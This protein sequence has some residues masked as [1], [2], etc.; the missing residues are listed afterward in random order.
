MSEN[1]KGVSLGAGVVDDIKESANQELSEMG[2]MLVGIF[3]KFLKEKIQGIDLEEL[4]SKKNEEELV[5]L[6]SSQLAEKGLV[7]K[8]YSGLP[9]DLLIS[10][11]HQDG[12]LDGLYA[13]YILSMMALVDN[14]APEE[15]IL[16]VRD[17]VSPNLIGH[18]YDDRDEFF[19]R[20]KDQKYNWINVK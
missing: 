19:S 7:P 10:N 16:S 14:D 18:H 5:A 11:M 1:K 9:E 13:G 4:F 3:S 2:K 20:Y 6:W 17:E 15:L 12:Y 8:G